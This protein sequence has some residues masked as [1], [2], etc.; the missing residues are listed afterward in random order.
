MSY[1]EENG[2]QQG[3]GMFLKMADGESRVLVFHGHEKRAQKADVKQEF[4][5]PDGLEVVFRFSE[6][7]DGKDQERLFTHKSFSNALSIAMHKAGIE[8]GDMFKATRHGTGMDTRY[9]AVKMDLSGNEIIKEGGDQVLR[10]K[11]GNEIPF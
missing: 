9:D 2:M 10:D 3:S 4:K 8:P 6:T 1:W 5:S 11:D 7:V